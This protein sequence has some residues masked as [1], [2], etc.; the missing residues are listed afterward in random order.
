VL[1][2]DPPQDILGNDPGCAGWDLTLRSAAAHGISFSFAWTPPKT[3]PK[4]FPQTEER[5]IAAFYF[6]FYYFFKTKFEVF[7]SCLKRSWL[8]WQYIASSMPKVLKL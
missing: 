8:L 5:Y 4:T 2:R 6:Y 7:W 1:T 3:V